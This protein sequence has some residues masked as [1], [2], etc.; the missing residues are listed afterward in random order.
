MNHAN[1]SQADQ[2]Q[3]SHS[4]IACHCECGKS[5]FKLHSTPTLR[6]RCH[7]SI[8]QKVY[9]KPYSDFTIVKADQVNLPKLNG[10]QFKKHKSMFAV[11]RGKCPSCSSPVLAW[12]KM[13]PGLQLAMIPSTVIPKSSELPPVD[14]DIFYESRVEDINDE[15]P[16]ISGYIRSEWHLLKAIL[17]SL[18][19]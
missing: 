6:F 1:S 17:R 19:Q 2:P 5:K 8:C 10:L 11:D 18:R 4:N 12:F 14:A 3:C 7:C 15:L 9:N 16:K 13:I